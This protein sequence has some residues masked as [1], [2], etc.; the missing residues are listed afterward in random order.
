MATIKRTFSG[1]LR[2]LDARPDRVDFRDREYQPRL[3]SLPP[4]YPTADLV[5]RFLP[6]YL[7]DKMILNQGSEGACTGFG[8]AA[9][10][11]YIFWEAHTD[12]QSRGL[13]SEKPKLVS[14]RMLY[15]NARLYD[16]WDGEDYQG[17]SCRGA[18]KGWHKH[19]V[20]QEDL[21]PYKDGDFSPP[22]DGWDRDAIHRPLG[23]YYRIDR[24]SIVDMQAAIHETHAIYA[25][26]KVHGGWDIGK[27]S[28]IENAIID[29]G[30]REIS[31]GHAF[32]L[33]GYNRAG[34]LVQNSWGGDW[35]YDGFGV[36]PYDDWV[37]NGFDAWA[38]ALGAPVGLAPVPQA[39]ARV[40]LIAQSA[41]E[42]S[43]AESAGAPATARARRDLRW[44]ET[45]AY[46]HA[47]VT[48]NEGNLLRRLPDAAD[49]NHNLQIVFEHA[50]KQ[51]KEHGFKHLVFFAHGGIT[52]EGSAMRHVQRLGPYFEANGIHPIFFV[53]KTG[54]AESLTYIGQDKIADFKDT[55]E[56]LR[57]KGFAEEIIE[58]FREKRDRTFEIAARQ[59]IGRAV[60]LQIKQNAE[61]AARGDG[62]IRQISRL[63]RTL[64]RDHDQ[65][66]L[67]FVGHSAGSIWLGHMADDFRQSR[68]GNP[69]AAPVKTATLWAPAC[70]SAFANR[71]FGNALK[72]GVIAKGGLHVDMLSDERERRDHVGSDSLY[73]KSILYLVSR[74]LEEKHK[75]PLLGL[76]MAW[77]ENLAKAFSD[78][79]FTQSSRRDLEDWEEIVKAEQVTF[80]VHKGPDASNG[81]GR[82]PV[83]HTS[84]DN[85]IDVNKATF[86]RILK[87][88]PKADI[89]NL[90]S[91]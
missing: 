91:R 16:E 43:P 73:G 50:R 64:L 33:V 39:K 53:W 7:D 9:V 42:D 48:G 72:H 14:P 80:A 26:A 17:S 74:A 31:G 46:R 35:G 71:Y 49:A 37:R 47:V 29:Q 57:A 83:S 11:N 10:I 55:L 15:N 79:V 61:A 52:N 58:T 40:A 6:A 44:D 51:I 75:T 84:F 88:K 59:F 5:D 60:W 89:L 25:S 34:F 45:R 1:Q 54:V 32:A 78:D 69:A 20:C 68:L 41:I 22:L 38:V 66:N 70:T 3:R 87:R 81:V 13:A 86:T 2:G 36:L 8:L 62:I 30:G 82:I 24:L 77:P 63:V 21:F 12:S 4:E 28:T 27:A 85:D 65:T 56:G 19:G 90:A 67:H 18:M 23:A 76:H